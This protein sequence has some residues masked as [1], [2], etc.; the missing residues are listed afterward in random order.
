MPVHFDQSNF[1]HNR[2]GPESAGAGPAVFWNQQYIMDV[3]CPVTGETVYH[4]SASQSSCRDDV[5]QQRYCHMCMGIEGCTDWDDNRPFRTN[6]L[7]HADIVQSQSMRDES[8]Q[9]AIAPTPVLLPILGQRRLASSAAPLSWT[10]SWYSSRMDTTSAPDVMDPGGQRKLQAP[11]SILA[12]YASNG[13][14]SGGVSMQPLMSRVRKYAAGSALNVT[15]LMLD[16]YNRLVNTD[17]LS[18]TRPGAVTPRVTVRATAQNVFLSGAQAQSFLSG[19]ATLTGLS[20]V[21]EPGSYDL[22]LESAEVA[23]AV[24]QVLAFA[25]DEATCL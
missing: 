9:G 2:C 19:V 12:S 14:A 4:A 22:L 7:Q 11:S 8:T 21:A 15:V 18:A 1:R 24:V 17:V 20:L 23:P 10:L 3:T 25:M 6:E 13:L 16:A 5:I